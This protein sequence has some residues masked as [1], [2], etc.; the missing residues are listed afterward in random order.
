MSKFIT[1][2]SLCGVSIAAVLGAL[3]PSPSAAQETTPSQH[4][5]VHESVESQQGDKPAQDQIAQLR[6]QVEQ[7]QAALN[8]R[9]TSEH[10]THGANEEQRTGCMGW[11][12]TM[13]GM[14]WLW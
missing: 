11:I 8:Q 1:S 7:L 12:P 2:A 14:G 10:A 3:A 4:H 5:A 13:H 9:R 6:A